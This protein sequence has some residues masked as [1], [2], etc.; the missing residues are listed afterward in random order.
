[1]AKV[2]WLGQGEHGPKEITQ[3]GH[4][5]KKDEAVEVNDVAVYTRA[6]GDPFFKVE[7][8]PEPKAK[9][10]AKPKAE[11]KTEAKESSTWKK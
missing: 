1:M 5:F 2:T 10:E 9:T 6:E 4:V 3:W 8:D 7:R 11:P